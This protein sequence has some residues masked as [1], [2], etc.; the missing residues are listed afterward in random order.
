MSNDL[1]VIHAEAE[2]PEQPEWVQEGE[3]SFTSEAVQAEYRRLV[4]QMRSEI[5]VDPALRTIT[6]LMIK[7]IA[8]DYCVR[9]TADMGEPKARQ[10]ERDRRMMSMLK[11]LSDN[12]HRSGDQSGE[13]FNRL[14]L[15]LV[16]V[17]MGVIDSRVGHDPV[18]AAKLKEDVGGELAAYVRKALP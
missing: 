4:T 13:E 14:V 2:Q 18:L 7:T 17:V 16:P 9:L 6:D 15:G 5:V 3:P 11:Q 8:R 10:Q 1:S 12:V